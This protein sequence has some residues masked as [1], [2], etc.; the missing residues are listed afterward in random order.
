MINVRNLYKSFGKNE[1]LKDIN[2]TIKKGEVVVIIGPSGS[3][4][5]TFL[6][7]LNLLEEPT[8]GVINFEGED[9]TNKNV[10][11]NKIR[12]KMGMVFQQ[13]N[14]FP[15]KTVMENLTIGPT[16]IKNISNG[17]A[18]KK[19]SEL[20]EKVGLLDKKNVYPNSLSG[21][22]KQRIAIARALA[23]EPDVMLFD[24][25]TS[26]LDPEMVGEVLGVMKS[27]AKD[28]MTMVVVTHEMG[29]AKEVG[30]RILF[31]DEGRI[32]E[33]GTPEEI[34]QNPKNSRTKDFLSKVL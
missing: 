1:V 33:E 31:M 22:Q 21:G 3:G 24:E 16:K 12:E 30:D 11:I 23:M 19:G 8:S 26:A 6:R 14:L 28:G 2:E 4:K 34:F 27:L 13:F 25:P 29:F 15:H 18:I 10:D 9:I 20:L 5:S 7:C 32:I 17:E